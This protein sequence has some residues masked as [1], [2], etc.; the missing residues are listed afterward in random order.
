MGR[1]IR[2]GGESE[3]CHFHLPCNEGGK[4]VKPLFIPS[5]DTEGLQLGG[6]WK[7]SCKDSARKMS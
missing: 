3:F 1:V 2:A 6:V 4:S 5:V 7:E